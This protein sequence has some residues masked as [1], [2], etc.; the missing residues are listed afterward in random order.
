MGS[1]VSKEGLSPEEQGKLAAQCITELM[2]LSASY[3][4]LEGQKPETWTAEEYAIPVPML[5]RFEAARDAVAK[6]PLVGSK[7]ASTIEQ[8]I[9]SISEAIVDCA[10][11]VCKDPVT[12]KTFLDGITGMQV[13]TTGEGGA[14]ELCQKGGDAFVRHL[15]KTVGPII[16]EGLK[17]VVD[18]VL[19]THKLTKVWGSLVDLYNKAADKVSSLEKFDFDLGEYCIAQIFGS[20]ELL[21]RAREVGC[22]CGLTYLASPL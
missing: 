5:P 21:V 6:V 22:I 16:Q 19:K 14:V 13:A 18:S 4:V 9:A 1:G 10:V 20:L 7:M 8:V 3:A 17:G 11:T 12:W 2:S 15:L